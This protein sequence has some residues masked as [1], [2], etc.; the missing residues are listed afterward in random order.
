MTNFVLVLLNR[1]IFKLFKHFTEIAAFIVSET[2]RNFRNTVLG[3]VKISLGQMQFFHMKILCNT[4][5]KLLPE[6]PAQISLADG[7]VLNNTVKRDI[8]FY[9]FLFINKNILQQ[10][11]TADTVLL[12]QKIHHPE[13]PKLGCFPVQNQHLVNRKQL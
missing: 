11:I 3:K 6:N 7:A 4:D 13:K 1:H 12:E 10:R 9:M 2:E 8:F 5:L